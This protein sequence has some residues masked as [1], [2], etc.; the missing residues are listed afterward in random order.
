MTAADG[1][2][3]THDEVG[4]V[5][6]N[7][8]VALRHLVVSLLQP[9]DLLPRL[10]RPNLSGIFCKRR[11]WDLQRVAE[12][13]DGAAELGIGAIELLRAGSHVSA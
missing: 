4:A 11:V 3:L 8:V 10:L 2:T 12:G 5:Q 9:R 7:D 13:C 1:H 6:L